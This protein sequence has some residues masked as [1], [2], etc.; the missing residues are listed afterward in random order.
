MRH[1]PGLQVLSDE[2]DSRVR[3][4]LERLN[5][6]LQHRLRRATVPMALWQTLAVVHASPAELDALL[7]SGGGGVAEGPPDGGEGAMIAG[8][9]D[10]PAA[11]REL[12][13]S[14]GRS[15]TAAD[16]GWAALCKQLHSMQAV[17]T[18]RL[19]TLGK[20]GDSAVG[21]TGQQTQKLVSQL[22]EGQLE[23]VTSCLSQKRSGNSFCCQ[24]GSRR[25][26]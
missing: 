10:V 21:E 22:L 26:K 4:V 23:V 3:E 14:S 17:L 5:L 20:P 19:E 25:V 13:Y 12:F 8:V 18:S 15:P 24:Q 11:L 1:V 16:A 6:P 9:E 2:R 7:S